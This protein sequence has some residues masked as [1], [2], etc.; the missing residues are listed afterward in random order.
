M[1]NSLL[2]LPAKPAPVPVQITLT[3]HEVMLG[4]MTGLMRQ[5]KVMQRESRDAH[6][7]D[8][9]RGLIVHVEGALG[10]LAVAKAID[11]HWAAR[12]DTYKGADL[13]DRIQVRTRSKPYYELIVRPDDQDAEAFVLVTGQCP[14]YVVHGWLWGG[15]AKQSRWWKD[16]G[17]D[18]PPAWIVP[19]ADLRDMAEL[20]LAVDAKGER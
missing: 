10:E 8:G 12:V 7:F 9:Q 16:L 18:R 20:P 15:E 3:W 14:T 1:S 6:G 4:G 17:N 19:Q 2:E 13:G 5:V 11:R